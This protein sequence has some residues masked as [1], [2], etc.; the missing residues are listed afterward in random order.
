MVSVP[1]LFRLPLHPRA[2]KYSFKMWEF[3]LTRLLYLFCASLIA[4]CEARTSASPPTVNGTRG[5]SIILDFELQVMENISEVHWKQKNNNQRIAKYFGNKVEFYNPSKYQQRII[6]HPRNFNVE[7]RD[8]QKN[9][10]DVYEVVVTSKSGVEKSL[11]IR[12]EVYDPMSGTQITAQ[13]ITGNCNL[14]LTCSV[15]SGNPT[16]ITWWKE[17]EALGNDSTHQLWGR[18]EILEIR[19]IAEVEDVAYLCEV[20]NPVSNDTAQ[21]RLRDFCDVSRI[22]DNHPPTIYAVIHQSRRTGDR[23][24]PPEENKMVQKQE[25]SLEIPSTVYDTVKS[26]EMP[27]PGQARMKGQGWRMDSCQKTKE[28]AEIPR[29]ASVTKEGGSHGRLHL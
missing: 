2:L 13:N 24:Q 1:L 15:T 12:L 11:S 22:D 8:L 25:E 4:I 21:I 6:L 26:T 29:L 10:S 28:Y 23:R 7:I 16:S 3:H 17:G 18:G 5:M 14:T 9:D 27:L 20:R 19:H